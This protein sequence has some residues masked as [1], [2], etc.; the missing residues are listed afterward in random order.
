MKIAFK[1]PPDEIIGTDYLHR[2]HLVPR[3]R[4]CNVY[5]HC[6]VGSDKR[7]ELHD[8]PWW[9]VSVLLRGGMIE[10]MPAPVTRGWQYW[11]RIKRW[12]PVVRGPKHAHRI[13]VDVTPT[14]TIFITGPKV[15]EWGF[16]GRDGWIHWKSFSGGKGCGE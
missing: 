5:L 10:V 8:H 12:W 15:R 14:W 4:L 11:K 1:R 6:F 2:W 9:S 13:I 7:E 16:W 3:N